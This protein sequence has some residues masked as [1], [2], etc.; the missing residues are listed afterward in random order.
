MESVWER[1]AELSWRHVPSDQHPGHMYFFNDKTGDAIWDKPA[2]LSWEKVTHNPH[3]G[4]D[5]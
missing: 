2:E 1:P 5:V 4:L 3:T